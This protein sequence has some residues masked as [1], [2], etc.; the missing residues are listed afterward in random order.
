[1]LDINRSRF[2]ETYVSEVHSAVNAIEEG[3]ALVHTIEGGIGKVRPSVGG[4]SENFAGIAMGRSATPT[5]VPYIENLTVPSSGAYT[6]TLSKPMSGTAISVVAIAAGVR[7]AL[8]AGAASN[9]GEYSIS[10]GVITVNSSK[11]GNTLEVTYKYAISLQEAIMRYNFQQNGTHN[12]TDLGTIGVATTGIVFTDRFDV[13]SNW[14][15]ATAASSIYITAD[16][17]FTLT[18]SSNTKVEV[19]IVS[20]PTSADSFL[21]L[22]TPSI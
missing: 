2:F 10:S 16:G 18:S 12:V 19:T 15:S 13:A 17:I 1:M 22:R 11:A 21:G 14:G 20:I 9:A 5:V 6:V 8:T 7:T 3:V 4:G